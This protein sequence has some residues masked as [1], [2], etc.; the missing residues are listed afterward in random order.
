M[1]ISIITV[2]FNSVET[3]EDTIK[4]VLSQSYE[5]I[6]YIIVD[7]GSTDG[8]LEIIGG[9]KN[10]ISKVISEPDNGI[11]D[12]MNKGIDLATG[13]FIGGLNSDDI[14][15]DNNV[16]TSVMRVFA[17]EGVD[18]VYGDLIYVDRNDTSKMKR[19][20]KSGEYKLGAFYKGWV[21]PHP[22]FFCRKEIYT[23]YGYF[24]SDMHVA[25]D[26]ELMLRFIEK[27][28]I[29]LSYFP[30]TLVKM[31]TG[32]CA[33]V[34]QG[35]IRGNFEIFRSFGINGLHISPLFFINKPLQKISQVFKRPPKL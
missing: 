34:W 7:G 22:T 18:A 17:T 16:L 35:I 5:N 11:Y 8:T 25:A 19:Y 10:K 6:E 31:R 1:K 12:A 29:K 28:M 32:G 27:H 3:I 2:C 33:N 15:M 21:P 23:N 30:E 14:Y 13:E 26:F 4:S 20:W 9:Y 24:R